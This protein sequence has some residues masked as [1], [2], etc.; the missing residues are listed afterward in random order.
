MNLKQSLEHYSEICR[1]L[2]I[3]EKNVKKAINYK[4]ASLLINKAIE[5]LHDTGDFLNK[6]NTHNAK[7]I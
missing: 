1:I 5:S 3:S 2:S 7:H 6:K 4:S